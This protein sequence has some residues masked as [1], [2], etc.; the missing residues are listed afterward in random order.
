MNL[1]LAY[2]AW[3]QGRAAEAWGYPITL[4][5]D[6]AAGCLCL[7]PLALI[8]IPRRVA[9]AVEAVDASA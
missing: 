5:I 7:I 1:A 3:W 6:A 9:I 8:S 2:S 4:S